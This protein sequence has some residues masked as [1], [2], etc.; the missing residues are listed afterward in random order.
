MSSYHTG[1]AHVLMADGSVRFLS[2]NLNFDTLVRLAV[3]NDG[4]VLGEF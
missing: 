2:N 3:A 1:G 4:D